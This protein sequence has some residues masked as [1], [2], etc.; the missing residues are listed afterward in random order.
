MEL[1]S[2][3][4]F[5]IPGR[6]YVYTILNPIECNDFAHIIGQFVLIDGM[7]FKVLGVERFAHM[8]PWHV[9]ESLGLLVAY[10]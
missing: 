6:G 3:G 9:G 10:D 8:P 1:K 7:K 4:K 5:R 2:T